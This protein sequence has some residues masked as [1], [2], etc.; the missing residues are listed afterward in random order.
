M[1]V[2]INQLI[3]FTGYPKKHDILLSKWS[4]GSQ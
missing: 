3:L 2:V 1:F 4:H